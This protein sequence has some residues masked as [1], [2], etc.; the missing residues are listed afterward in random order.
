MKTR[1]FLLGLSSG[2]TLT[3]FSASIVLMVFSY[4]PNSGAIHQICGWPYP[5]FRAS[6][7]VALCGLLYPRH[8]AELLSG[9]P[10]CATYFK[11]TAPAFRRRKNEQKRCSHGRDQVHRY[12]AVV[13]AWRRA[14]ID[15]RTALELSAD[16]RYQSVLSYAYACFI[17]A[18]P[19]GNRP[20]ALKGSPRLRI[21]RGGLAATPRSVGGS[22]V[23]SGSPS[24]RP[25]L[26]HAGP[27][28]P[29][30]A[31]P[32]VVFAS[33]LLYA[34]LLMAPGAVPWIGIARDA[35]PAVAFFAPAAYSGRAETLSIVQTVRALSAQV[36]LLAR[37]RRAAVVPLDAGRRGNAT[38]P[39]FRPPAAGFSLAVLASNI[40]PDVC[41][42][43]AVLHAQDLCRRAVRRLRCLLRRSV[44]PLHRG[45]Q[46]NIDLSHGLAILHPP[47]AV[48]PPNKR[49]PGAPEEEL[50]ECFEV[51]PADLACRCVGFEGRRCRA[52][53]HAVA[54]PGIAHDGVQFLLGRTHGL[55]PPTGKETLPALVRPRV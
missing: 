5:L 27:H 6:F 28:A 12:G 17:V 23:E 45:L 38:V 54:L 18:I 33:F 21:V 52:L 51:Q 42:R 36:P 47:H 15:F 24:P 2:S 7:L 43:R 41:R 37:R 11:R 19:R 13:F 55:G 53:G 8:R 22:R 4:D 31:P 39:R 44:R 46:R 1:M 34:L 25:Q 26:R 9:G 20:P 29:E 35:L 48:V 49:R 14:S 3:L 50:R 40:R 10:D 30:M 16:V 32:Q